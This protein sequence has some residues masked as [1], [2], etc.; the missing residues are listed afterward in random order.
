MSSVAVSVAYLDDNRNRRIYLTRPF[1]GFEIILYYSVMLARLSAPRHRAERRRLRQI[2]ARPNTP[3]FD[4][5]CLPGQRTRLK[6]SGKQC[7]IRACVLRSSFLRVGALSRIQTR[8]FTVLL[9]SARSAP[10]SSLFQLVRHWR[11]LLYANNLNSK[12]LHRYIHCFTNN[13]V[14]V[15]RNV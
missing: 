7:T 1:T 8:I 4:E 12:R 11:V 10:F 13:I 14:V 15:Y 5:H 3:E 2:I 6:N 9:S